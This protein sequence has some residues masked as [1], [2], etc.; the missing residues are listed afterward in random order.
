VALSHLGV[1]EASDEFAIDGLFTSFDKDNS[2]ELDFRELHRALRRQPDKPSLL[3]P[4]RLQR[5]IEPG[6]PTTYVPP[7]QL[8]SHRTDPRSARTHVDGQRQ[9][10]NHSGTQSAREHTQLAL[11]HDSKKHSIRAQPINS[12]LKRSH[13][14]WTGALLTHDNAEVCTPSRDQGHR[15]RVQQDHYSRRYP[16]RMIAPTIPILPTLPPAHTPRA[17]RSLST[18]HRNRPRP[19]A[20][21]GSN[22]PGAMARATP[23]RLHQGIVDG[24][25]RPVNRR[26]QEADAEWFQSMMLQGNARFTNHTNIFYVP[27][28]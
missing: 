23:S 16:S 4:S 21:Q 7:L 13:A 8:P 26:Q 24:A 19:S 15:S 10:R 14:V 20:E 27:S 17:G 5:T 28:L 11:Q 18:R 12:E 3:S 2:G 6:I 25:I 9:R 1:D 22:L